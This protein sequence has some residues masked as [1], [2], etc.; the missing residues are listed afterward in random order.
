MAAVCVGLTGNCFSR[1]LLKFLVW[2]GF[3][4]LRGIRV[5]PMNSLCRNLSSSH[6]E[7]L[8]EEE[9]RKL[10]RTGGFSFLNPV[11]LHLQPVTCKIKNTPSDGLD[12]HQT[13]PGSKATSRAPLEALNQNRRSS[14]VT[15]FISVLKKSSSV[16]DRDEIITGFFRGWGGTEQ[17]IEGFRNDFCSDRTAICASTELHHNPVEATYRC[18]TS[19][20]PRRISVLDK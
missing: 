11:I 6:T 7:I 10:M 12:P 3:S 16:T 18:G 14:A 9:Q 13:P 20:A 4:F 8:K 2:L 17:R 5:S 19:V 15:E 1:Q